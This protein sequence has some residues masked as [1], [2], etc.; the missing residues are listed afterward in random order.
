MHAD[1]RCVTCRL[2]SFEAR[3]RHGCEQRYTPI[4]KLKMRGVCGAPGALLKRLQALGYSD[5]RLCR[6]LYSRAA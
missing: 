2:R 4:I 5:L 1:S 6:H 3:A